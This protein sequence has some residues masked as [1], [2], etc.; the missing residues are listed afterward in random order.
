M[1]NLSKLVIYNISLKFECSTI[2]NLC[3]TNKY[4]SKILNEEYFWNLKFNLDFPDD[5]KNPDI[6]NY[7]NWYIRNYK[8][9]KGSNKYQLERYHIQ[10]IPPIPY[11][12]ILGSYQQVTTSNIV[13]DKI[14]DD[15]QLL[16]LIQY[17]DQ[18]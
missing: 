1:I 3:L 8:I 10:H 9:V 6:E 11:I 18:F 16:T 17:L 12:Y 2:I 7:K 14:K 13:Y 4:F 5:P 15:N